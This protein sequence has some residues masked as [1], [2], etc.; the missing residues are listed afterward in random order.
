MK[1]TETSIDTLTDDGRGQK[2]VELQRIQKDLLDAAKAA[3]VR[4]LSLGDYNNRHTEA[5][6]YELHMLSRSISKASGESQQEVQE[7]SEETALLMRLDKNTV[8][9]I[10]KYKKEWY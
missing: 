1:N 7:S 3:Y 9:A 4:L 8:K 6:Q 2:I 5:G 10:S